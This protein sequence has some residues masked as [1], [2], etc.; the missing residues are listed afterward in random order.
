VSGKNGQAEGRVQ[1]ESYDEEED[2][3]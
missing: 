2:G 3:R 1:A